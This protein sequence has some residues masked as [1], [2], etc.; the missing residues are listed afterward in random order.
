MHWGRRAGKRAG[1]VAEGDEEEGEED[2]QDE[3]EDFWV[4]EVGRLDVVLVP[5]AVIRR[6]TRRTLPDPPREQTSYL[7]SVVTTSGV[8][9]FYIHSPLMTLRTREI[10]V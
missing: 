7:L 2:G 9:A 3:E 10:F 8:R 6:M 1:V 4:T 5:G